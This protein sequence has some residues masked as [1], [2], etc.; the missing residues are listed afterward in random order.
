MDMGTGKTITT[1]AVAGTLFKAG[2]IKRL[3]VVAP[4]S[5]V[6]VW[7]QEFDKFAAFPYTL[8]VLDGETPQFSMSL[9][10][11]TARQCAMIEQNFKQHAEHIYAQILST[12]SQVPDTEE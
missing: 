5:I 10:V 2:H 7:Q 11:Y 12:V 9:M 3:L 6:N 1:I 4:K 8:A